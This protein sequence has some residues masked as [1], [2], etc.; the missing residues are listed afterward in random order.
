MPLATALPHS[1][2]PSASPVLAVPDTPEQR[3][4]QDLLT[5]EPGVYGYVVLTPDGT[6]LASRNSSTPF[7]TASLY[8]LILMA[9]IYQRIENGA[10]ESDQ[11]IHL[12]ATAFD[13]VGDMYF[14]FDDIGAWFPLEDYLF[15]VGAYSSNAAARTLLGLTSPESLRN[16][17]LAIGM[18]RTY[19]FADLADV[20]FWPPT[21]GHDASV[22]D[23]ALSQRY[24]EGSAAY[25]SINVTT[26]LDMA[27][28]Q[29][30]LM[31]GALI[32]PWVSEQIAA[33]LER[34][35]IRDRIPFYFDEDTRVLNKPGN[36]EDAVNDVGVMYLPDGPRA[37][38]MLAQAVPDTDRA[39]LVQQRLALIASGAEDIPPMPNGADEERIGTDDGVGW[40]HPYHRG[41]NFSQSVVAPMG[42]SM[43][44]GQSRCAGTTSSRRPKDSMALTGRCR[45]KG[46]VQ[47]LA[48]ICMLGILT[49]CGDGFDDGTDPPSSPTPDPAK[50]PMGREDCLPPHWPDS[51]LP[52]NPLGRCR[53]VC[54]RR[55]REQPH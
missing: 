43:G 41:F 16:T 3:R 33:V 20:P 39:T 11:W 38:A 10:L 17:A 25:G 55:H 42:S 34:Q 31:H 22:E 54:T 28:Y 29:F 24:L 12:E 36:L 40:A 35:L 37:I 21:P 44:R 45:L 53:K 13:I 30:A 49:G 50:L 18:D 1:A 5:D 48:M 27:R 8:K 26:P 47:A 9:D 7:I 23:V 2:T 4:A 32:S 15:A 14:A 46:I 52:S 6:V 51:G 19:L